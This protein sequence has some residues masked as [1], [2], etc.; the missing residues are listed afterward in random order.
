MTDLKIVICDLIQEKNMI[1]WAAKIHKATRNEGLF[2]E[3]TATVRATQ[4]TKR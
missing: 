4:K 1:R 2:A 3:V